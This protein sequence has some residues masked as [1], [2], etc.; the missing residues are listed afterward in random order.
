MLNL[1]RDDPGPGPDTPPLHGERRCEVLI[2]GG[3][4]TGLSASLELAGRGVSVILCEG[5]EIAHGASGR[6]GGQVNPGLKPDPE[7]ILGTYG[8]DL[9]LRLVK[10]AGCAPDVVFDL[11]ARHGIECE[12]RRC[13]MLR[14]ATHPR[15]VPAV[16]V[17]TEQYQRLGAP[18]EF[19]DREA[20]GAASGTDRYHG[21]MLDRRGG[22]VQPLKFAHGLASAALRAGASLH[23]NSRIVGLSRDA[24][25]WMARSAGGS[26]HA[27]AVLIATNGYTDGLWPD[28]RHTLVPVFSSIAATEP[29]PE[30]VASRILPGGEVLWE[31]GTV[32]VYYRLDADGRLLI[33]GRGPMRE[34]GRPEDIGYILRYA[35]RL[36]PA[37]DAVRWTHGWSGQ[38]AITPDHVPHVHNPAPGVWVCLGYNGRGVALATALGAHLARRIADPAAPLD[39]P[40]SALQP[41]RMHR[42]W[43]VGVKAAVAMGRL[44][45][46]LGV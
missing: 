3:G 9:G 24:T 32:T 45:D 44:R 42:F 38:L 20:I 7:A 43:P 22:A 10:L 4:F 14:A 46:A 11:I 21:A 41:I 35:K 18:V 36:W 23:G 6:N 30:G 40:V 34:I 16:R 19:L 8:P 13:G 2:V 39:I 15:L 17:T 12:A 27:D 33:G 31:S 26:V 5:G 37:L 29:L 25:G 1:Y 28:L